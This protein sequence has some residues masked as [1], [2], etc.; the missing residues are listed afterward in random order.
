MKQTDEYRVRNHIILWIVAFLIVALRIPNCWR[1][2]EFVG[3]DAWVF[4]AGAFN[5]PWT[6]S[7]LTPYAGYFHFLPRILAELFS[8]LPIVYQPYAYGIFSLAFNAFIFSIFYF[9]HFETLIRDSRIR[10]GVVILMALAGNAENLGLLLGL[11]WY[12]SFA[13]AMMLVMNSPEG[14]V[15]QIA[16][17]LLAFLTVWSTP[18]TIVLFPFLIWKCWYGST[19][20]MRLWSLFTCLNLVAVGLFV[21]WMRFDTATRTGDFDFI[22]LL[23]GIERLFLRGW[24]G[25]GMLGKWLTLHILDFHVGILYF[26]GAFWT[27]LFGWIGWRYRKTPEIARVSILLTIAILMILLS[28]TRSLYIAKM[29]EQEL[30]QH[31]R[32]LT[33]PTLL[34]LVSI[35]SLASR[36]WQGR[37]RILLYVFGL[38]QL[39]LFIASAPMLQHASNWPNPGMSRLFH[40]RDYVDAIHAFEE[41]YQETGKP[42]TLYIP[43]GVHYWGPVLKRGGGA[44][45]IL[46]PCS[47]AVSLGVKPGEDG[48]CDS[49]LGRFRELPEPQMIEHEKLGVLEFRGISEGRVWFRDPSGKLILITSPLLYPTFWIVDGLKTSYT[50]VE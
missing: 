23:V 5:Q 31:V 45:E 43:V 38:L 2:G 29:S 19:R 35:W 44:P 22:Q 7:I 1:G 37:K 12:L 26:W 21:V 41:R 24:L 15:G 32:Y 16:M 47:L 42:A 9:P 50:K 20:F 10:A 25:C 11:H 17:Y 46:P 14:R 39:S 36:F 28:L 13:M 33:V 18:V 48:Y 6:A 34:L 27:V 30:P 40:I 8:V 49:W 3:E 4:F